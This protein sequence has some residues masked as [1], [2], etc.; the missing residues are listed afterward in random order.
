[1]ETTLNVLSRMIESVRKHGTVLIYVQILLFTLLM[2]ILGLEYFR[3]RWKENFEMRIPGTNGSI[4][5]RSSNSGEFRNAIA[6]VPSSQCWMNTGLEFA[7]G[8]TIRIR[9]SGQVHLAHNQIR[10]EE[11]SPITWSVPQGSDFRELNG[12]IGRS[13]FLILQHLDPETGLPKVGNLIGVFHPTA[14]E[15]E[16]GRMAPRPAGMFHIGEERTLSNQTGK[17]AT[18]WLCVNDLVL[19]DSPAAQRA[20]LGDEPTFIAERI[21]TDSASNPLLGRRL[22][23]TH[24]R[25]CWTRRLATWQQLSERKSWDLYFHDNIGTYLAMIE[26]K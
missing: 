19:D 5:L 15:P 26:K 6:V 18:L 1:M 3:W 17:R 24:A 23:E 10:Q 11:L 25:Q 20:Y 16:P 21:Q 4:I 22:L 12:A 8:E 7:D 14:Q 2:L 9:A 13:R